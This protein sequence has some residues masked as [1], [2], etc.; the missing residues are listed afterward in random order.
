M[1]EEYIQPELD[2]DGF[3]C[4]NCGMYARQSWEQLRSSN[5]NRGSGMNQILDGRIAICSQCREPTI[6]V[7]ED[8][9]YPSA[10]T[11]PRPHED[12]PDEIK[13]DYLEARQL[14]DTSPRAAAALLRLAME[15]L[16]RQLTGYDDQT[17]N[18]NIGELVDEGRIDE[19]IQ[20]ALDSVRVTGND[21]VH[22]G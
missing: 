20:K 7:G 18:D 4:P 9:I 17:L 16:T 12:M 22:P 1:E 10:S 5:K 3:H 14:V 13:K 19:R 2:K 11:A 6:W 21:M 8:I 15:K